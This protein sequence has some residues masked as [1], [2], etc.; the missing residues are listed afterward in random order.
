[1]SKR[2]VKSFYSEEYADFLGLQEEQARMLLIGLTNA[3]YVDLDIAAL[4]EVKPRAGVTL[5]RARRVDHD[6]LAFYSNPRALPR[7]PC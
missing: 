2:G 7:M 5:K 3:G 4:H 6:V 1:M